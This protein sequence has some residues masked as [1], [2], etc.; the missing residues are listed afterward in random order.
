MKKFVLVIVTL[1]LSATA[2]CQYDYDYDYNQETTPVEPEDGSTMM[3]PIR[4]PVELSW[5]SEEIG[6][7]SDPV[8]YVHQREAD[9]MYYITIWRTIDLREKMNHHLYFPQ[10]QRGSWKSLGQVILDAIDLDHPENNDALRLYTDEYCNIPKSREEAKEGL[11]QRRTIQK[12]DPIT[13]EIIGEEELIEEHKAKEI[14]FYNIKEIWFFDKERSLLDVRI[15]E[16]EPMI[17][18][19]K[20]LNLG[21]MEEESIGGVKQ[22]KRLGYIMYDELRPYLAQQDVFNRK[23]NAQRLSL[24]D[25][26]TW[27]REFTSFI[28]AEQNVYGDR[29][30]SDYILNARD[31]RIESDKIIDKIRAFEHELWEY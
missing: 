2:W 5:T 10:D 20:E 30:I 24:D 7:F 14:T 16:I 27:K 11:I 6:D 3:Q 15:L 1:F 25:V 29:Y 8:T 21:E 28:Y 19:E 23:N 13:F 4:P 9:V 26:L 18:Y 12:F 17:E 31:Q 22:K